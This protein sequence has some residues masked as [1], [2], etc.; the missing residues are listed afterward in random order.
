MK[1]AVV[2]TLNF[3]PEIIFAAITDIPHHVDWVDGPFQ[4]ISLNDGPA[5]LG[6]SWGQNT[7]RLGKKLAI[8]NICN[9]YEANRKFGW[10][11]EKPFPTQVTFLIEPY[12]DIT[13]FTW[14]VQSEDAGIVQLVEPML[15]KQTQ[16]MIQKSLIRLN[17]YLQDQA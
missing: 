9:I 6:T 13:K 10:K 11:T 15:I 8:V 4:L 12:S 2:E 3:L 5:K 16:E 1:V 7:N 14:T 17:M